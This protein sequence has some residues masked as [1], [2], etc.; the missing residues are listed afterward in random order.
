MPEADFG[1]GVSGI[2]GVILRLK[3]GVCIEKCAEVSMAS[4]RGN[5]ARVHA[6]VCTHEGV[7]TKSGVGNLREWGEVGAPCGT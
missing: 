6:E 2:L 1:A 7:E 4:L 5:L 3:V